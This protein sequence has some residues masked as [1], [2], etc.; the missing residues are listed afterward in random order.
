[1]ERGGNAQGGG[2][3][4]GI[5]KK[6]VVTLLEG[7]AQGGDSRG[8]TGMVQDGTSMEQ[9]GGACWTPPVIGGPEAL[10]RLGSLPLWEICR[11]PLAIYFTAPV[12]RGVREQGQPSTGLRSCW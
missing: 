7:M 11:A 10:S 8:G 3:G 1:M 4:T 12:S 6:R 9:G 5:E 2:G